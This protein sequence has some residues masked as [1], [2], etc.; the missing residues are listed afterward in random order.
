MPYQALQATVN[1]YYFLGTSQ[2][3][4]DDIYEEMWKLPEAQ[5][6]TVTMTVDY[7]HGRPL[8]IVVQDLDIPN[9]ED[10]EELDN[11]RDE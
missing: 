6:V 3:T 4:L 5:F 10:T 8:D 1:D 9:S 2:R 11:W 7:G